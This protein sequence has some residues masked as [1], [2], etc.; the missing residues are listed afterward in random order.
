MSVTVA[1]SGN[2][3]SAPSKK[4]VFAVLGSIAAG[5]GALIYFGG[6]KRR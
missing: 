6:K 5:I 3:V 2:V 4:T 1:N